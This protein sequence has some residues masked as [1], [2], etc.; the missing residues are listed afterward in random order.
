MF[1]KDHADHCSKKPQDT[2]LIQ[3]EEVQFGSGPNFDSALS[4][5]QSFQKK[6]P[7][8]EAIPDQDIPKEFDLRNIQG[9]DFTGKIRDQGACGSCY[10][11]SFTQ[12][13]ESRLKVKTGKETPQLSPQHLMQCN[14][15]TEGCNGGWAIMHG[16]L[17][18]NG[19][20]V[21]EKCAPYAVA[22]RGLSCS[23]FAGCPELPESPSLMN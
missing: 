14:Y 4:Y 6:Y 8:A 15:M 3:T 23:Q 17:A 12:A 18:E 22:T 7:T 19:Y 20:L 16:Y 13:I 2:Q 5:V 1:T 10:T 9:V 21:E 11:M